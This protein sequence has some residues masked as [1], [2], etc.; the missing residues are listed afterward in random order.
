[1]AG[2]CAAAAGF[3]NPAEVVPPKGWPS[4][5]RFAIIDRIVPAIGSAQPD[6][7]ISGVLRRLNSGYNTQIVS[8]PLFAKPSAV[9]RVCASG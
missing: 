1:L 5:P 4:A 6:Y 8:I 7:M 9:S 3:A 2:A